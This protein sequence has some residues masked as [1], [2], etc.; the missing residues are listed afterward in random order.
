MHFFSFTGP[1]KKETP[2][3]DKMASTGSNMSIARKL[4]LRQGQ[5]PMLILAVVLVC[6]VAKVFW[7]SGVSTVGGKVTF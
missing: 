2:D 7:P 5:L 1:M 4:G 6:I 3:S